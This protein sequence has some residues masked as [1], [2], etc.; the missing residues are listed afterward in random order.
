[1]PMLRPHCRRSSSAHKPGDVIGLGPV[2][3]FLVHTHFHAMEA[4]R[5]APAVPRVLHT[6]SDGSPAR[7]GLRSGAG[8]CSSGTVNKAA[9]VEGPV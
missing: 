5:V 8:R 9:V 3:P 7:I 4:D 1:M 6:A 2:A